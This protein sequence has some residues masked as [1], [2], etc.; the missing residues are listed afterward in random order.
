MILS[1]KVS[2]NLVVVAYK[3]YDNCKIMV[4]IVT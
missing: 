3:R 1:R 4:Q 2:M